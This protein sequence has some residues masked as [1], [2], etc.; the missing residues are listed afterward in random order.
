MKTVFVTGAD[1]GLGAGMAR[2]LL[3]SGHRVFAGQYMPGW[4]EL[5]ELRAQYPKTLSIVPLDAGDMDS[6]RAAAQAVGRE[7]GALDVLIN[8]AAIAP[9]NSRHTIREGQ[10]YGEMLKAYNVNALGYLRTTEAFLPLMDRSMDKR[11]CYVSSEAG[12][13]AQSHRPDMFGYC[14]SKSALNMGVSILFNS[15]RP[16]GY[17]FRLY[18]PGWIRSYM[19]GSKSEQGNLEPDEAAVPAVDFFL[20]EGSGYDED[21]LVMMDF[22]GKAWDW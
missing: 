4:P 18:Y 5:G 6:V 22:E 19:G 21:K 2:L 3:A 12:S 20:S 11:L 15:L 14:M 13:I 7:C 1:R 10:D 17:T 8:N 16:D 9:G